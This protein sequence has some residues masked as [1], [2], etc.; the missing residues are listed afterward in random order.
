MAMMN[1]TLK[2]SM[3]FQG[4]LLLPMGVFTHLVFLSYLILRTP[5]RQLW[6]KAFQKS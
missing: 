5:E 2:K 6:K 3:P 1:Q 4:S